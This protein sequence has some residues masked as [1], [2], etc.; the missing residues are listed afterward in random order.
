MAT[1]ELLKQVED[2]VFQPYFYEEICAAFDRQVA[3]GKYS[4]VEQAYQKGIGVLKKRLSGEKREFLDDFERVC[5]QL[6]EASAKHGFVAGIYCG[7]KQCL[8]ACRKADGGFYHYVMENRDRRKTETEYDRQREL[9]KKLEQD[10]S[11][12]TQKH[13]EAVYDYWEEVMYS[14]SVH[15]FYCGYRAAQAI[16]DAVAWGEGDYMDRLS[17]QIT[18]EYAFGYIR[19]YAQIENAAERASGQRGQ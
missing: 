5:Q 17:K 16:A 14:A 1:R 11:G 15:G 8:T 2:R 13:L 6:R 10:S 19:S 7:F 12:T 18:V 3:D 9:Y 4:A